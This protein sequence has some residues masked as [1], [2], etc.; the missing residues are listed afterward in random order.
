[1]HEHD[2]AKASHAVAEPASEPH[3][4]QVSSTHFHAGGALPPVSHAAAKA[5]HPTASE[6]AYGRAEKTLGA[7]EHGFGEGGHHFRERLHERGTATV[8]SE[9]QALN[10]ELDVAAHTHDYRAA[11]A[12]MHVLDQYKLGNAY[13]PG[14]HPGRGNDRFRDDNGW[15]GLDFMQAYHQTGNKADLHRAE[16]LFPFL[17][18]GQAR[19]GGEIWE[20][21]QR[22]PVR[23]MAATGSTSEVA[24][25]L[26][27]ATHDKKYLSFAEKNEQF[28]RA[29]LQ[30]PNHTYYDTITD[31][32]K[33]VK[34]PLTY[35]QGVAIGTELDL[36]KATHDT[37]YLDRAKQTAKAAVYSFHGVAQLW[38]QAPAFN[39]IFFRNLMA[40]DRVA[41]DPSYKALLDSYLAKA[42]THAR[43]RQGM[44]DHGRIGKY[45]NKDGHL[46]LLDESAFAEMYALQGEWSH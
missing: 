35:N 41:P 36:F 3:A 30:A 32:G 6:Q 10:A 27:G 13:A 16:A 7:M 23:N 5:S 44:F 45:D 40:L 34:S 24:L 9:S 38:H 25:E 43:D 15:L 12:T 22:H 37:K 28:M 19:G 8:W 1:M 14:I 39:A 17:K 20:E 31:K 33:V 46:G 42:W 18:A 2:T 4:E 11:N 26:Y 21:G 29:H